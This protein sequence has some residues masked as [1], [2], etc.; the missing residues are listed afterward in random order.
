MEWL[1]IGSGPALAE[2]AADASGGGRMVLPLM[3][4]PTVYLP[5]VSQQ[6]IISEPRY[7]ALYDDILLSGSRLFVVTCLRGDCLARTGVLFHLDDLN[8]ISEM[9]SDRMK[10]VGEHTIRQ[11]VR[12]CSLA[13]P[14]AWEDGS[15]YL[16]A[17]VQLLEEAEGVPAGAR[18]AS[19]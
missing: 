2:E 4:L 6:L 19:R 10:F 16:R 18:S 8:E 1:P 12:L 7:R 17:K 15:T 14:G 9:T 5:S 11:R 13:N 3:P